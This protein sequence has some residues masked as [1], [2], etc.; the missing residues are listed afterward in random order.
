MGQLIGNE[1]LSVN[2]TKEVAISG[3][4]QNHQAPFFLSSAAE[5]LFRFTV[6]GCDKQK[7]PYAKC[8]LLPS[9]QIQHLQFST[10]PPL[11][12]PPQDPVKTMQRI[13]AAY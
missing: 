10:S 5:V 9:I 11:T 3:T 12:S 13:W 6:L 4:N 2:G 7:D 1:W 8:E